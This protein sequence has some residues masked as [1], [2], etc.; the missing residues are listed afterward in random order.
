[1]FVGQAQAPG[2]AQ[3]I[4]LQGVWYA[5][6]GHGLLQPVRFQRL[7]IG[8]ERVAVL[9]ERLE[10]HAAEI[11]GEG[12][13]PQGRFRRPFREL[14]QQQIDLQDLHARGVRLAQFQIVE[15]GEHVHHHPLQGN[16]AVGD[17][18]I[19]DEEGR[20]LFADAE[21]I[22]GADDALGRL[23]FAVA[24]GVLA[25]H[26]QQHGPV[27]MKEQAIPLAEGLLFQQ[28]EGAGRV[29]ARQAGVDG[30]KAGVVGGAARQQ[31]Q[32]PPQPPAG[33]LPPERQ[34]PAHVSS[35]GPVQGRMRALVT[36]FLIFFCPSQTM[37]LSRR[38]IRLRSTW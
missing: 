26:A 15:G 9:A 36:S 25:E 14:A 23:Q 35:A 22:E 17:G 7:A 31:D 2:E 27:Q 8:D 34:P 4:R 16:A 38:L 3:Q 33:R 10:D 1:M 37:V 20:R 30:R 24:L 28:L 18:G 29:V 13:H 5:Q 12:I 19:V 21:G 11:A 6:A 32:H